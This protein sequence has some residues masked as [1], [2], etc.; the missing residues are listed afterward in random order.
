MGRCSVDE[1]P[2][3]FVSL[4]LMCYDQARVEEPLSKRAQQSGL[5]ALH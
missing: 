4:D 1:H 5:Q 2:L 3:F